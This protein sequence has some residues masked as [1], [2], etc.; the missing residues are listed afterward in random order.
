MAAKS[1]ITTLVTGVVTNSQTTN[2]YTNLETIYV[3]RKRGEEDT[4]IGKIIK[5]F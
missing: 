5:L 4:A 1:V 3:V 2:L